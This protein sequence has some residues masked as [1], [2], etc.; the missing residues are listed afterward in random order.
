VTPLR[1]LIVALL[2]VAGALAGVWALGAST[3][4][5][6]PALVVVGSQPAGRPV[7]PGFV[8]TS[9]EYWALPAY[10]GPDPG[11]VNPLF[12]RLLR[13]L[14]PGQTPVVRIGGNSTDE[15]W[16]PLPGTTAPA[17][18]AYSLTPTWLQTARGLARAIGGKLI[19]GI[20]TAAEDPALAAV[21]A[22][23]FEAG[24]G[25][26]YIEA[27]ELG[28]EAD[29]YGRKPGYK[30]GQP[31]PIL[32]RP[33]WYDL[34]SFIH[35]FASVRRALGA[36]PVAGPAFAWRSW[37]GGLGRFLAA[38]PGLSLVTFHRYPLH[39]CNEA[40]SA[41]GAASIPHLLSPY[42]TSELAA[43]VAAYAAVAHARGLQ[44]R[45]DELGSVACA[46]KLGVSDT[47]ASALWALD[48]LFELAAVGVDGVNFH[49]FPGAGYQMFSF[50]LER[51]Q[52]RVSVP[53]EY[54][55][56]KLFTDAAPPGARLLATTPLAWPLRTW[57][58]RAT[59][60]TTRL[61]LLNGDL[62]RA[63]PVDVA[64]AEDPGGAAQVTWLLA[65]AP[66]AKGGV[67]LGGQSFNSSG[68]LSGRARPAYVVATA[69]RYSLRLPPASAALLTLIPG[70][71]PRSSL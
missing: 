12:A 54:Y 22:H 71:T 53:P 14:A 13:W 24:I 15:T 36:S 26:Q 7:P 20:N 9:I 67:T 46:G 38:E 52:W 50:R 68:W 69:G 19:L 44:F 16:W 66:A 37:M 62:H 32:A 34:S 51:G 6:V 70:L 25:P 43:P 60:G 42:S 5:D 63:R 45:V 41:P 47:F 8:G 61:L 55:G 17:K 29:L 1:W 31:S 49:T 18:V 27:L 2:A 11:A 4:A 30:T 10:A 59:D 64:V 40:P 35:E 39:G 33:A 21:E 56:L 3:T 23:E 57:A 58:T 65:P 48:T 28:N